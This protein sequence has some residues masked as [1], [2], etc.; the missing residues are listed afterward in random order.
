MSNPTRFAAIGECMLELSPHTPGSN[1]YSL[2]YAGDTFN[3][4]VGLR[5]LTQASA[6]TVHYFTAIGQDIYSQQMLAT[7]QSEGIDTQFISRHPS[8][9]AGLYFIHNRDDGEREFCYYR[10]QSAA[11]DCLLGEA[12]EQLLHALASMDVVY[13]TG[14]SLAIWQQSPSWDNFEACLATL[15]ANNKQIIFDSN[16][17]PALWTNPQQTQQLLER[18]IP[19]CSL[20]LSTWDDEVSLYHDA[21]PLAAIDRIAAMDVPQIVL[22]QGDKGADVFDN[23]VLEKVPSLVVDP[24][25]VVDTTGAGDGFNAGVIAGLLQQKSLLEACRLG[26]EMAA[27]VIQHRGAIIPLA[28]ATID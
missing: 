2:G 11:R 20:V 14:I 6:L 16:I 19:Y 1:L 25:A 26:H 15:R 21:S 5:R 7:M 17:R 28:T 3:T 12:G 8:K 22:K 13:F 27:Q 23:G 18:F 24:A 4:A 10:G 9:Q